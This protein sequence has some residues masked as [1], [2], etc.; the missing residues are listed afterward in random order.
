MHHGEAENFAKSPF[1]LIVNLTPYSVFDV[2]C[3]VF[4]VHLFLFQNRLIRSLIFLFFMTWLQ[5]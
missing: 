1:R 3:S 4:G 5:Q 2:E